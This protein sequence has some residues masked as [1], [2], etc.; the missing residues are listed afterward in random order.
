MKLSDKLYPLEV[1]SIVSWFM[2]DVLWMNDLIWFSKIF[3]AISI[4]SVITILTTKINN[5]SSK[6]DYSELS[7]DLSSDMTSLF[8]ILMNLFWML[9]ESCDDIEMI[10]LRN[11]FM[12]LGF[13]TMI[14]T[15]ITNKNKI[16]LRKLNK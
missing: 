16:T 10:A 3:A 4:L 5:A 2:M 12:V 7:S 11:I 9:S 13:I 1:V 15:L 6:D 14:S 8:W